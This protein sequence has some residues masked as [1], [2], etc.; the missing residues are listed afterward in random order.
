[1]SEKPAPWTREEFE[2]KLREKESLYHINHPFHKLMH[3]GKLDQKQVQG[4]VANRFYYQTAIPIKD[5]ANMAHCEDA[6][7]RK[8]RVHRILDHDGTDGEEGGM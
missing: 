6:S 3:A 4:W 1:M 8:S 2:Q 5:A 7:V